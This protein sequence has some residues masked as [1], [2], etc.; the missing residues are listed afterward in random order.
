MLVADSVLG[1]V[2]DFPDRNVERVRL[3]DDERKRSRVRTTTDAGT[4]VGL[5]LGDA[6]LDAGD[7]V[8]AD[9]DR[10]VAVA[11]E[12]LDALVVDLTG[13]EG[14]PA[15]LASLV[16]LGH[17]IGNRHRNLAVRDGE[18]VL[19]DE[20]EGL[21]AELRPHLPPGATT[22]R[23]T[24]DPTLF[25]ESRAADHS[26]DHGD[27]HAHGHDEEAHSHDDGDGHTH[28]GDD[29]HPPDHTGDAR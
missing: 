14:G 23:E 13:V 26:H 10:V 22:R 9:A 3:D 2:E 27:G 25:D 19:P 20:G 29:D 15:R 11:F 16:E 24:V 6:A 4:D 17:V 1:T 28:H 18:V 7:V 21:D 8:Y 12:R 5:V